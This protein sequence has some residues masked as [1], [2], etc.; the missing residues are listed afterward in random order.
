MDL[1]TEV[2]HFVVWLCCLLVTGTLCVYLAAPLPPH[3]GSQRMAK[4]RFLLMPFMTFHP[5]STQGYNFGALGFKLCTGSSIIFTA[6]NVNVT[7]FDARVFPPLY[8]H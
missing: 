6:V 4:F 5:S 3:S 7:G 2:M 8:V 1:C